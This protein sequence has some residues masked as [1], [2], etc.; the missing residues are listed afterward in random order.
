[1]GT[2]CLFQ[3]T[4]CD[5]QSIYLYGVDSIEFCNRLGAEERAGY[6]AFIVFRVS[7]YCKCYVALP[8]GAVGLCAV[9]HCGI[10]RLYSLTF[11]FFYSECYF[12][13]LALLRTDFKSTIIKLQNRSKF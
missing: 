7:R 11:L 6:L 1:M 9:C 13:L 8:H 10:S 3:F 12:Y 5:T 2:G 4:Y